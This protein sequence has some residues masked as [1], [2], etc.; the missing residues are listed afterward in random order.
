MP[1]SIMMHQC[2]VLILSKVTTLL[3]SILSKAST[4]TQALTGVVMLYKETAY[5]L[6]KK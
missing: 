5:R 4:I 3:R 6:E 1:S 2:I